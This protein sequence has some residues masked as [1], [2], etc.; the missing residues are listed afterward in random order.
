MVAK[1]IWVATPSSAI[2]MTPFFP[3]LLGAMRVHGGGDCLPFFMISSVSK[4][5]HASEKIRCQEGMIKQRSSV[6]QHMS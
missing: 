2:T 3:Y 6:L 4:C 1:L 5:S